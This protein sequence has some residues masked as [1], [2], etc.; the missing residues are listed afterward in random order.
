MIVF[1][2]AK[3]DDMATLWK[4]TTSGYYYALWQEGGKQR[5][6]SLKTKDA[7][8]AKRIF[9]AFSEELLFKEYNSSRQFLSINLSKFKDEY[10]KHVDATLAPKSREG[11]STALKKAIRCWGDIRINEITEK[12]IDTLIADMLREGLS[13]AT[14]N[15]NRQHLKT[16]LSKAY[17]WRYLDERIDFP[18]PLK[19]KVEHRYLT[20]VQLNGV[21]NEI[22][23]DEFLDFVKLTLYL[24]MRSGEVIRLKFSDIDEKNETVH[25]S[26]MQKN[27][28]ESYIPLNKIARKIVDKCKERNHK[29]N[30]DR[31]FRF[32][33]VDTV[34]HYFKKAVRTAGFEVHRLH[35][36]R[37]TFGSKLASMN[38]NE[39]II[40][41]LM[42]HKSM[43]ST[44]V[45][46]KIAPDRLKE[47][48]NS[49][50]YGIDD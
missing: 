35:D 20:P 29:T 11:Y 12:H 49:L 7:R 22:K 33:R 13:N 2:L 10:L 15:K 39:K 45:Y 31:L 21:L 34:S 28:E 38:V 19:V 9:N 30:D 42:R 27:R 26:S 16:A 4:H 36:L 8:K 17:K 47:T 32:T 50:D 18:P 44:L 48:S 23:D 41:D 25:I 40:Q 1:F 24:G 43:S 6:K 14:A 5:S 37:H 46:T 3:G